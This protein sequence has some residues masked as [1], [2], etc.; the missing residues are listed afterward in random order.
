[1][2]RNEVR[3]AAPMNAQPGWPA[4]YIHEQFRGVALGPPPET[5][6]SHGIPPA[7]SEAASS[8]AEPRASFVREPPLRAAVAETQA[9][10]H[11]RLA[12]VKAGAQATGSASV[13]VGEGRRAS[14]HLPSGS[15]SLS[16]SGST[17]APIAIANPIPTPTKRVP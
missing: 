16:E 9:D 10:Y 15:V 17:A 2:R 7:G 6:S 1:M 8:D 11:P 3:A 12:D 5:P 4:G 14:F 13:K